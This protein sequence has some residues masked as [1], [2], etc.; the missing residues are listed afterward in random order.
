MFHYHIKAKN[1]MFPIGNITFLA[2]LFL[3][4]EGN[5][6]ALKTTLRK[7]DLKFTN[8][9]ENTDYLVY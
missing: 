2:L 5:Y 6:T 1:L 8:L 9:S 7:F 4:E 3:V